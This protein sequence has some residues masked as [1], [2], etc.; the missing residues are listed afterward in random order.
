MEFSTELGFYNSPLATGA[1]AGGI[2]PA[3]FPFP[4]FEGLP[5][6]SWLTIGIESTPV[7][8]EVS[9]STVEDAAQ[10]YLGAF[11]ATSAISGQD[12]TISTQTGGAWYVLNG[13][14]NGLAGDDGQ[15]LVMQITTAGGLSG[16]LNVQIFE[17]GDGQSDIRKS[18]AFDGVGTFYDA[19]DD[20]GGPTPNPGCTDETACNY[21]ANA[22]DSDGSCTFVDGICETCEEGIIVDNDSDDDGVCDA[23][24]VTGC[25]DPTACNYDDDPTTDS[26]QDLC[27]FVDGIC[28]TCE[29]DKGSE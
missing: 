7:G 17:N 27:T 25:T 5:A 14:P 11:T 19:D 6:D 24:E 12:F 2:N 4:G 8:D 28:E 1:T 13:T 9:I 21:D 18:F 20:T 22:T 3:F 16:L 26:D 29:G 15:V 23:N 10:P